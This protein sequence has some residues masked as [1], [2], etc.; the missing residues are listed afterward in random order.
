MVSIYRTANP[1]SGYAALARRTAVT[2]FL[3]Q[4]E[5]ITLDNVPL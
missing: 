4:F 1:A 2:L 5:R 3:L